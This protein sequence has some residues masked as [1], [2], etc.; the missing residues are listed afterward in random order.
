MRDERRLDLRGVGVPRRVELGAVVVAAGAKPPLVV[1][2]GAL[3]V[4]R[5]LL[6]E[7]RRVGGLLASL[8]S[9]A[10]S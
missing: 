4:V 10:S 8:R 7:D 6:G 1:L 2:A 3:A 5:D 9:C